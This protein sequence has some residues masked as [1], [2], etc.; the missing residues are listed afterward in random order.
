MSMMSDKHDKHDDDAIGAGLQH[1]H[2]DHEC[3]ALRGGRGWG[4]G[5]LWEMEP[6]R[7]VVGGE[8]SKIEWVDMKKYI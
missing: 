8:N 2:D 5:Y 3:D 7:M 6:C 4:W 1:E